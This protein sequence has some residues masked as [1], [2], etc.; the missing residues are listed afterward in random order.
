[1]PGMDKLTISAGAFLLAGFLLGAP[2]CGK[3]AALDVNADIAAD[4]VWSVADSPVVINKAD[5]AVPVGVTL[6]IQPGVTVQVKSY[7]NVYGVLLAVGTSENR[8]SFTKHAGDSN[9]AGIYFKYTAAVLNQ[10]EIKYADLTDTGGS[11]GSINSDRQSVVIDHCTV[12][13]SGNYSKAVY[14]WGGL[15]N[16]KPNGLAMSLTNSTVTLTSTYDG[17]W[18]GKV[19]AVYLDGF[20][21]TVSGNT[22]TVTSSAE[23]LYV[24]GIWLTRT[25]TEAFIAN[26]V[27]NDITVTGT[28][29][30]IMNIYGI[31]FEHWKASGEVKDNTINLTGPRSICGVNTYSAKEISGND[32]TG[33]I[34]SNYAVAEGYGIYSESTSA[35]SD[36]YVF[37]NT[38]RLSTTQ[39]NIPLYCI[40]AQ[41]GKIRNN[42]LKASHSGSSG[43]AFGIYTSYYDIYIENNSILMTTAAGVKEYGIYFGTHNNA[44]KTSYL[45]NNIVQGSAATDSN[46]IYKGSGYTASVVNGYNNSYNFTDAYDGLTPGVGALTSNPDFADASLHLN[47]DSPAIDAGDPASPYSNEPA[48]NGGRINMGAYGNTTSAAVSPSTIYV[49]EDGACGGKTPCRN[50]IQAAIEA[51]STGITIKIAGGTYPGPIALST[52]KSL[53]LRGGWDSSF[54]TQTANKTFIKAP[55]AT[56]G[57]LTLQMVTVQP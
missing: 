35:G 40:Y 43:K 3:V 32:I 16:A 1:M 30:S 7:L 51:A 17:G 52:P 50:T 53:I 19:K 29:N 37:L 45:K 57:S 23:N 2:L 21:A 46:G 54:S 56:Q 49:S 12:S 44:S 34:T 25:N 24:T 36:D 8:I 11:N 13:V 9:W 28:D 27:N 48:P 33:T 47:A 5:F 55:K 6:T 10:N 14:G 20:D 18:S 4:T 39:E 42:V 38:V 15:D 22:I 31:F 41:C 26:I